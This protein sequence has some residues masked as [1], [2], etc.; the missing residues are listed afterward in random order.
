MF[1]IQQQK[2]IKTIVHPNPKTKQKDGT[3]KRI[4]S[5]GNFMNIGFKIASAPWILMIS[6]DLLICKDVIR[7]GL[8][9]LNKLIKKGEKIGGGAIYWRDYPRNIKYHIRLLPGN[10]I[11]IN[12]GF[13]KKEALIEIGYCDEDNYEFYCADADLTMRLN[14]S[15]WKTI[16]LKDCFAEHLNHRI[17]LNK[18]LYGKLNLSLIRDINSF[19]NKYGSLVNGAIEIDKPNSKDNTSLVFWKLDPIICFQGWLLRK[20]NINYY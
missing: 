19:E 12:H 6:D 3:L 13:F 10:N 11:H 9:K 16:E 15:G 18:L 20:L 1:T 17:N 5:W 4:H 14:L 8:D 2:D 7:N